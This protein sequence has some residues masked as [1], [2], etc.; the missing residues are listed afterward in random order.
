MYDAFSC[1]MPSHLG[2]DNIQSLNS[3]ADIAMALSVCF[4]VCIF[5]CS[6]CSFANDA[7]AQAPT[8][9]FSF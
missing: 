8:F 5:V 7:D 4:F 9:D 6:L 2:T 3:D 1:I